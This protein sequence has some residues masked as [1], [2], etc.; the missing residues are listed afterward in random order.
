M[1]EDGVVEYLSAF[2]WLIGAGFSLYALKK[3]KGKERFF[4]TM[5]FLLCFL[6]CGEEVSWG[7]RIF[8]IETPEYIA[9]NNKQGELNFH[10]LHALSGG[11]TWRHFFK[12]GEFH[13]QQI[14]DA[15]NI[16]RIFVYSYFLLIPIVCVNGRVKE[17]LA[18]LGYILPI[19]SSLFFLWGCIALVYWVTFG[20]SGD[21]LHR[22]QEIREMIFA[23]CIM[24]YVLF[25]Y[26]SFSSSE[27]PHQEIREE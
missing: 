6:A 23:Y 18:R 25:A 20:G 26:F 3:T 13:Y 27:I 11:N 1:N 10:N 4:F 21:F 8:N 15:Q 12:T 14:L 7:Q 5:F 2:F 17:F 19:K 24:S 16:F 9:K 22:G